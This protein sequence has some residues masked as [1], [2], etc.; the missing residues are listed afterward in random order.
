MVKLNSTNNI[1]AE[2][3]KEQ[4][5]SGLHDLPEICLVKILH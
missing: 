2:N 1:I 3:V 4:L 5:L